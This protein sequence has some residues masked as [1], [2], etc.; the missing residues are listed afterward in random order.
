[1]TR[2]MSHNTK[3]AII[4]QLIGKYDK[5]ELMPKITTPVISDHEKLKELE[6]ITKALETLL[7]LALDDKA[8]KNVKISIRVLNHKT[9]AI[10][11]VKVNGNFN[12]LM[13]GQLYDPNIHVMVDIRGGNVDSEAI[14]KN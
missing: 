9:L 3:T 11:I 7:G 10:D 13:H 14:K 4:N 1:M 5:G 8:R 2:Y 6:K 12:S